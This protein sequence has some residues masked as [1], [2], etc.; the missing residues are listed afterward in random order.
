MKQSRRARRMARH[1]KRNKGTPSFNLVSLMALAIA[2]GMVVDN[3]IVVLENITRHV[4][5]GRRI[6][7]AAV[8]GAGEMGL[9]ITASRENSSSTVRSS[10]VS[11]LPISRRTEKTPTPREARAVIS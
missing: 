10:L 11:G 8:F 9:A 2:T 5:N 6:E 7:T 3:G 4:E 1:H